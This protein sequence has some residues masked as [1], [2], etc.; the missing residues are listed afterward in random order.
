MADGVYCGG[1]VRRRVVGPEACR[2]ALPSGEPAN[3]SDQLLLYG[4]PRHRFDHPWHGL[5]FGVPEVDEAFQEVIGVEVS[6]RPSNL[7]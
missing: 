7:I 5:L 2:G 6:N 4:V 1:R 3:L